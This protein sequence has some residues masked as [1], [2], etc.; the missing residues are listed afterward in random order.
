MPI[1]S[2]IKA[3]LYPEDFDVW[4]YE[5]A[6]SQSRT[7]YLSF[8]QLLNI[9]MEP[10]NWLEVVIQDA[11]DDQ[12]SLGSKRRQKLKLHREILSISRGLMYTSFF[13][14]LL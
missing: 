8:E 5:K 14:P 4:A 6:N 2:D 7:D 13:V 1:L 11:Y 10:K 3:K 9:H 12:L